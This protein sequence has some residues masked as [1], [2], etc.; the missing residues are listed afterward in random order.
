MLICVSLQNILLYLQNTISRIAMKKILNEQLSVSSTNPIKARSYNYQCYTYPWHCHPEYELM[1]VE[2]GHGQCLVGDSII[3]YTDNTLIFFGPN[4]PHCMQSA[5]EY[6]TEN[7]PRVNG[8]IIQFEKDFMHYAFSNYIQFT[9][10]NELLQ[11]TCRGVRFSMEQLPNVRHLLQ[12]IPAEKGVTQIILI[13]KLLQELAQ[14]SKPVCLASPNYIPLPLEVANKKIEK[15]ISFL[16]KRYTQNITLE[17]VSSYIA[18]NPTAFCRYF[19]EQTGKTFKQYILDMRIGYACK[20][21]AADI[22]NISQVSL[23]CGFES[24]GHFN[25][26][27]KKTTGITPTQY[28]KQLNK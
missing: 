4:L 5:P 24:I 25:R 10:I 1:Y 13:L 20:L 14:Q 28:K 17:E 7:S 18:M 15:V 27:F 19:K 16:N 3:S 12:Q 11:H 8:V 21:L 22:L 23:E 26:I 2:K 6:E 9:Q